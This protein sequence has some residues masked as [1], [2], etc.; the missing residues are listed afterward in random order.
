MMAC[1]NALVVTT[2][3]LMPLVA[4]AQDSPPTAPLVIDPI[5]ISAIRTA[6]VPAQEAGAIVRI[7]VAAGDHVVAGQELASLDDQHA[8]LELERAEI[9]LRQAQEIATSDLAVRTAEAKLQIA[10]LDLKRAE[11]SVSRYPKSVADAQLD[12]LRALVTQANLETEQA[13]FE[14]SQQQLVVQR[15]ET[16]RSLARYRLEKRRIVA[17][18]AGQ[19]VSVNSRLGEWVEPGRAVFRMVDVKQLRAEGFVAPGNITGTLPGRAAVVT[20]LQ[21]PEPPIRVRGSVTFVSP[22]V[23]RVDGRVRLWVDFENPDGQILPGSS[24]KL[25][26]EMA[27]DASE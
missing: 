9:D 10:Q 21:T 27:T 25:E 24:G 16:A 17:P 6:E 4:S 8:R 1:R 7:Q 20:L 14:H 5:G 13:R 12:R 26:I 15:A 3:C 2:W 23:N 22:E 19:V 11:E 18:I